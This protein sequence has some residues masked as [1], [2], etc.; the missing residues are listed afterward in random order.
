V[1]GPADRLA[2]WYAELSPAS[3]A[4]IGDVYAPEAAFQ[5]PFNR[6]EGVDRIAAIFRD[7]FE[8]VEAPHF[9]VLDILESGPAAVLTWDFHFAWRGRPFEV[10]GA[11]LVRF[12]DDG[13]VV[14]HRDYWDAAGELYEKLPLVGPL[15][16]WLRS[17]MA[18]G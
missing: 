5:D 1:S 15:M 16:R 4:T 10:H 17:R 14:L 12:G 3:L 9:V 13:R 18:A 8:S 2:R 11:T 7:M 6:V